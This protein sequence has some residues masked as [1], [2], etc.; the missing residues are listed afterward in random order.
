MP[1]HIS[2]CVMLCL[3]ARPSRLASDFDSQLDSDQWSHVLW[4]SVP[5]RDPA[6]PDPTQPDPA[7]PN[8]TQPDP[9]CPPLRPWRPNTPMRPPPYLPLI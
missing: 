4:T 2:F 3:I 8:S 6:Q 1:K 5:A 7:Q 9:A